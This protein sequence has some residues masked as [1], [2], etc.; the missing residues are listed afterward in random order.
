MTSSKQPLPGGI[1]HI[2]VTVPDLDAATE[3]LIQGLG[4]KVAYDGLTSD[5]EP[6]QGADLARG[7]GGGEPGEHRV[8][9]VEHLRRAQLD[10]RL[11]ASQ[12]VEPE[13]VGPV[14]SGELGPVPGR[15]GRGGDAGGLVH[16]RVPPS[17]AQT[18]RGW[19]RAGN[20]AR[21]RRPR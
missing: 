2:G 12:D 14:E 9:A 10:A 4:A 18:L 11:D 15:G 5:D 21:R 20:G 1:Q 7:H 19:C 16:P 3:F 8:Q 13:G 17:G 6:R